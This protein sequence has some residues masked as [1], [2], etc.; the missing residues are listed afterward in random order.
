MGCS[1]ARVGIAFEKRS[2]EVAVFFLFGTPISGNLLKYSI[3]GKPLCVSAASGDKQSR[4][5]YTHVFLNA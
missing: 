4:Q 3:I 1:D 5:S 2:E